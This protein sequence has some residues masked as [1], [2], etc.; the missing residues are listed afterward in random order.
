MFWMSC[1]EKEDPSV[2]IQDLYFPP[3]NSSSWEK[4]NPESL[5]WNLNNLQELK[6]NLDQNGTRAFLILVNG[7]IVV[8]EYFGKRLV[9]NLDFDQNS[10]WYWASAGKV[11]TATLAGLAQKDGFLDI[12]HPS[13]RYLGTG[14]TSLAPEKEAQIKIIHQLTM[15]T[16]L[17]DRVSN[18]DDYSP[19]N[20]R[21]L[22]DAGARWAYHNAPYTLLDQV[23]A[24]ATGRPFEQYFRE[25]IASKIGMS[26]SWQRLGFNHV[27]F[28]DARSMAR[29]G[30]LV[31][32]NG[33]WNGNAVLED[34]DFMKNMIS[35][36]QNLNQSYG[37]LW[38][39]NGQ[40]S[41]MLPGLQVQFP[42]KWAPEAP[43]DMVCG[44]GKN[45]QYL[46][47]VPSMNL[48]LVRMGENPDQSLVPFAYLN[49]IWKE[50][51]KIIP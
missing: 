33:V 43:D 49:D 22:A 42:G 4:T 29:F 15:T 45:G 2:D 9:G 1:S 17:D 13:S 21:F 28:S 35:P 25:K 5:G 8:K 18:S 51:N 48:V 10:Q 40:A 26:G 30:L 32:A 7:R 6:E 16:G 41:F 24:E 14:W 11:L 34:Q 50:L 31:L 12:N 3:S 20:L 39:L 44:L 36:S 23:I 37:Y 46:C 47:V 19:G 27:Y 38:W